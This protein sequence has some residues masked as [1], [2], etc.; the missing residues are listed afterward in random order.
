AL[1]HLSARRAAPWLGA[2]MLASLVLK[3]ALAYRHPGFWTGDDVEIHEM[4]FA[5][6]FGHP[7]HGWDIRSPVYPLGFVYPIQ[8][9]VAKAGHTDPAS[10]VFAGR[11]VVAAFT[12]ATLW[13]TFHV[14]RQVFASNA[15]S[16]DGVPNAAAALGAPGCPAREVVLDQ[17]GRAASMPIAVFSVLILATNKLHVMT[18]TTELPRP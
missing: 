4:T 18:G 15:A 2:V 7:W 6:L 11:A 17:R 9:L 5:R 3:L 16:R 1:L 10:L 14:A 8:A 13:L 12:I